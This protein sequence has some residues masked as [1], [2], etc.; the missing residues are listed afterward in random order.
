MGPLSHNKLHLYIFDLVMLIERFVLPVE[1]KLE[2]P[3]QVQYQQWASPLL[4][5]I[6]LKSS[7]GQCTR[8]GLCLSFSDC[9]CHY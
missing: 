2:H 6:N 4:P 3:Q 7:H 1:E 9:E 5:H 8:L